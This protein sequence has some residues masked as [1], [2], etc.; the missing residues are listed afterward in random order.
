[1]YRLFSERNPSWVRIAVCV[2]VVF[3]VAQSAGAV[4]SDAK[5]VWP[6]PDGSYNPWASYSDSDHLARGYNR[7]WR[8][9]IDGA[10]REWAYEITHSNFATMRSGKKSDIYRYRQSF[11][12][13]T[14]LASKNKSIRKKVH[15]IYVEALPIVTDQKVFMSY[16]VFLC[17]IGNVT[18]AL[19]VATKVYSD[20]AD[21]AG[22]K[23]NYLKIACAAGMANACAEADGL[24]ARQNDKGARFDEVPAVGHE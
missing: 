10:V 2:A 13:L 18:D 21:D 12:A 15:D 22:I 20:N 24:D 1:M 11:R 7:L 16:A 6:R 17:A 3:V 4:S 19:D 14:V 5:E 9:D 23:Y 8:E